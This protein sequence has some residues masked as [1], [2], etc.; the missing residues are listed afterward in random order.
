MLFNRFWVNVTMVCTIHGK[1]NNKAHATASILGI[2]VIVISL[3]E[4]AA[5]NILTS[6]P[7]TN[8]ASSI[9]AASEMAVLMA[10]KKNPVINSGVIL[11]H[12]ILDF[13][14]VHINL[15]IPDSEHYPKL[16]TSEPTSRFHPSAK[17][18]S[19]NLNGNDIMIGGS[20][21]IPIES[22]TLATT[23]SMIRNGT[24]SKSPI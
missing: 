3:I 1:K 23:M 24:Y 11:F 4:V 6:K 7:T 14:S 20:I 22:K 2:N 10:S 17:T 16:L 13:R 15:P 21:I 8:P 5:W 12:Y 9:G 18:N 19:I